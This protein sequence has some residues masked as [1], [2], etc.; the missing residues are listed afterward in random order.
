MKI[1]VILSCIIATQ[2]LIDYCVLEECI[3]SESTIACS[4]LSSFKPGYFNV[5]TPDQIY[6]IRLYNSYLSSL[7]FIY[8]FPH[9][10]TFG[11]KECVVDCNELRNIS[12]QLPHLV[13]DATTTCS[14]MISI[15]A[16][17][18]PMNIR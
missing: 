8:D 1:I 7:D 3:C 4:S 12:Q 11:L 15:C 17:I 2:G 13:I 6:L 14:G 18:F 5:A 16:K 9:L 10:Q